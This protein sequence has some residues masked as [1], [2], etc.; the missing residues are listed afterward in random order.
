MALQITK[1]KGVFYLK[2]KINSSTVRFFVNYFEHSI[3]HR[4][5]ITINLNE[6]KEIDSDGLNAI[7]KLMVM[8]LKYKKT[9]SAVGYNAKDIYDHFESMEVA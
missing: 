5:K 2:G 6:I 9:F 1:T 4:K 7:K 8:A 3:L